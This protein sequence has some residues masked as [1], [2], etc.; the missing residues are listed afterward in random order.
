[1]HRRGPDDARRLDSSEV[2]ANRRRQA[3]IEAADYFKRELD[4]H[5]DSFLDMEF[6]EIEAANATTEGSLTDN[7]LG[8]LTGVLVLQK[9]LPLFKYN[10]PILGAL[11][12]DFSATPGLFNV[13][14]LTRVIITPAVQEYDPTPDDAGRPKG[15][16]TVSRAQTIDVPIKLDSYLGVPIVFSNTLLA[17][18]L[19]RL[20]EEQGPAAIYAIAKRFVGKITALLTAANFNAYAAITG[21]DANGVVKVPVAYP[22]YA[23]SP[24][25][26]NLDSIQDIEMAFDSNEVPPTD[27]GILLNSQCYNAAKRDARLSLFFAAVRDEDIIY[28]GKLPKRLEGFLP[29]RAPWLPGTGDMVGFGFHKA[30]VVLKQRLPT[31]WTT[32]M[33]VLIPGSVTTVV[34]PDAGLSC[35][36]VQ[37]INLTGGWAE[38]RLETMVGAGPGDNRGGLVLTG[39]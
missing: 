10:Y 26:F 16:A 8:T 35:L 4:P 25:N 12:Q 24:K 15:W 9:S 6:A 34:G 3:A 17:G 36:L 19:R 39:L 18:T 14:E 32:A 28:E 38:W 2:A 22:T 20:F 33:D 31:D 37:Y 5:F 7:Y 27:R 11:F 1:L 23:V 21:A 13:A 29:Y 30:G